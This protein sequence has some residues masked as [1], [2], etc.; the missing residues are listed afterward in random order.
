MTSEKNQERLKNAGK[1]ISKIKEIK[2]QK[3]KQIWNENKGEKN[4]QR[5]SINIKICNPGNS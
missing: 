3:N 4:V 2:R 5:K 1:L